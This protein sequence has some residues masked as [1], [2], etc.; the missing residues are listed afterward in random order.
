MS[1]RERVAR[2]AR[3]FFSLVVAAGA[4]GCATV[5]SPPTMVEVE[6][7]R[8]ARDDHCGPASVAAVYRYWK[9]DASEA[10]VAARIHN[11]E[12]GGTLPLMVVADARRQGFQAAFGQPDTAQLTEALDAGVPA[13]C[14]VET[15]HEKHFV[16]V[17]GYRLRRGEVE[18]RV[19]EGR[20][21]S[22][23]IRADRWERIWQGGGRFAAFIWPAGHAYTAPPLP[24]V[25]APG[26]FY[27]SAEHN[28]FGVVYEA[29]GDWVSA[30]REFL[31][32]IEVDAGNVTAWTNYGNVLQ[33]QGKTEAARKAYRQAL[34]LAPG[35]GPAVNNLA[36]TYREKP[37]QGLAVLDAHQ[38]LAEAEFVPALEA[39]RDELILLL[40]AGGEGM[41][42]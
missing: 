39:T 18:L 6:G 42:R 28:D 5:Y 7:F 15:D 24:V 21:R 41:T 32:A 4:S 22:R 12:E 19:G 20:G 14:L 13:I 16:V 1:G 23:W 3:L 9:V 31:M 10:G 17:H 33:A 35:H 30:E 38:D 2:M 34:V 36:L 40:S 27:S 26:F 29:E 11:E 8:Q 37:R 25:R